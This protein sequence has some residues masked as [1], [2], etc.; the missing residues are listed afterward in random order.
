[1][2]T[3]LGVG[4]DDDLVVCTPDSPRAVPAAEVAAVATGLGLAARRVDPVERA[5]EVVLSEAAP[6]DAVVVAGSLYLVGAAR[7]WAR[8]HGLVAAPG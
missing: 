6:D 7:A 8:A 1:M 5:L 2:L 3:A 4:R